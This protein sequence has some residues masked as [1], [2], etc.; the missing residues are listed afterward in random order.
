[1]VDN[2]FPVKKVFIFKNKD[3]RKLGRKYA[4]DELTRSY[5]LKMNSIQ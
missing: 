3:T 1:M 4:F 2:S 5:I